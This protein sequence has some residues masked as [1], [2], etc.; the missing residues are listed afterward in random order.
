MTI[1]LSSFDKESLIC[2]SKNK[3]MVDFGNKIVSWMKLRKDYNK[4]VKVILVFFIKQS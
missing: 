2:F 4:K 3:N 1:L